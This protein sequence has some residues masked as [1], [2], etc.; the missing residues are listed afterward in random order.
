MLYSW[1]FKLMPQPK[2]KM[3]RTCILL[4]W[5]SMLCSWPSCLLCCI[6][7]VG[8]FFQDSLHVLE[9]LV[10]I[11]GCVDSFVL[12]PVAISAGGLD[13]LGVFR[14]VRFV[15]LARLFQVFTVF[16]DLF[17]VLHG[18]AC[19]VRTLGWVMLLMFILLFCG[20][21]TV[22][23]FIGKYCST[24]YA[25]LQNCG[26]YFGT[27]PRSM[28]TVYQMATLD[29]WGSVVRPLL[30]ISPVHVIFFVSVQFF[31][32]YGLINV[33]VAVMVECVLTLSANDG[34]KV[35]RKRQETER[36]QLRELRKLFQMMGSSLESSDDLGGYQV[37]WNEF[38]RVFESEHCGT[39]LKALDLPHDRDLAELLDVLGIASTDKV[40]VAD[41]VKRA[42]LMRGSATA[43]HGVEHVAQARRQNSDCQ[44]LQ[45]QLRGIVKVMDSLVKAQDRSA[46]ALRDL[47][48]R[49]ATLETKQTASLGGLSQV[50]LREAVGMLA[51]SSR[52]TSKAVPAP[53]APRSDGSWCWPTATREELPEF[54]S[55]SK[56]RRTAPER[57][58]VEQP[59]MSSL[60]FP[61]VRGGE[62]LPAVTG[63]VG[64]EKADS[65]TRK[66]SQ[67]KREQWVD[68]DASRVPYAVKVDSGTPRAGLVGDFGSVF[69][70]VTDDGD[71]ASI[72]EDGYK[73]KGGGSFASGS[74]TGR[75]ADAESDDDQLSCAAIEV[76]IG[77]I[78]GSP[79]RTPDKL[80]HR[81]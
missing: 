1:V 70:A 20:G 44:M 58:V 6:F 68:K 23:M 30:D 48:E 54:N 61:A 32:T 65:S 12:Q 11:A 8:H 45:E 59:E 33:V 34:F 46:G 31:L 38:K 7:V 5:S 50:T 29:N 24:S 35:A 17:L 67:V 13:V 75:P 19:S 16:R 66:Q 22:T 25:E 27:V 77:G 2:A 9:F 72:S 51:R 40:C 18:L 4:T 60:P 64:A 57:A 80:E 47:A 78:M 81:L 69:A 52:G 26:D 15:R 3:E 10:I 39:L 53:V 74:H 63:K 43:K 28:F 42:S 37:E 14:V 21:V 56:F 71:H 76:A 49:M 62:A 55:P 73:L 79:S 36:Q 41:F